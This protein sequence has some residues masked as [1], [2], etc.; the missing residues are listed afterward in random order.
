MCTRIVAAICDHSCVSD[1]RTPVVASSVA[2]VVTPPRS[3]RA[4]VAA[5][6]V[7]AVITAALA[8]AAA[9]GA[10][11]LL[12]AVAGV[13]CVLVLSWTH[14]WGRQ[15]AAEPADLD[16]SVAVAG[17]PGRIGAS[18]IGAAAA[19]GAD[20]ATSIRPHSA[21]APTLVVLGLAIPAMF[22]HQLS[23]GVVRERVVESLSGTAVLVVSVVAL[24]AL[25]QLRHEF[26]GARMTGAAVVS[27]G[28]AVVVAGL[29]DLVWSRPRFDPQVPRGLTAVVIGIA[30]AT[31]AGVAILKP[32]T[33]YG[34]GMAALL[35]GAV[36]AA[37]ALL[38]VS[39]AMITRG[40]DVAT[41]SPDARPGRR[42]RPVIPG[43]L[44]VALVAPVAYL[45]LLV[46]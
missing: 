30:G 10:A 32:L 21:L 4:A 27:A 20:V 41:Q 40:V 38:S 15:A 35:C 6:L 34:N 29:V 28:G 33:Q 12:V 9:V 36:A 44:P 2:P 42:I 31:V 17:M 39:T 25:L 16:R 5:V 23:R 37:A 13:Q 7:T 1:S 46:R 3:R 22:V 8:G 14:E 18:V 11:A 19:A 24:P 45:L 43:A 26:D